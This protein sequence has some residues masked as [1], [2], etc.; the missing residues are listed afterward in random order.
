[1]TSR[2]RG[3][4]FLRFY[5]RLL[6]AVD[7][8]VS[9]IVTVAVAVLSAVICVQVFYRYVLNSSL[10]WSWD[11]VRLCFIWTALL[12]IPLALKQHAHVGIDLLL[13]W[14]PSH[15][16]MMIVR[17]NLVIMTAMMIALAYYATRLAR[18]TWP[19]LLTTIDVS[20][21][22]LYVALVICSIHCVM[23]MVR[24]IITLP[25]LDAGSEEPEE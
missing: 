7:H 4:R 25:A 8:S 20:V 24:Q 18:I 12:A 1:M 2:I 9:F 21:G 13:R 3:R 22:V 11:V 10:D 19:Q 16:R 23:H 17:F 6:A 15:H 14:L 5:D